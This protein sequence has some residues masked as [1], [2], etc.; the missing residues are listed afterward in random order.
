VVVP[1]PALQRLHERVALLAQRP[2]GQLGQPLRV[3]LAGDQRLQHGA[4]GGAQDLARDRGELD[5]GVLQHLLDPVDR[6]RALLDQAGAEAGQVAQGADRRLRDEAGP[7]QAVLQQLRQPLTV[8]H[9]GL[10]PG[11]RLDV[12]GVGQHDRQVPLQ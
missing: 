8:A 1:Q 3:G 11:D 7:D 12:V 4:A 10:A 5:V 2:A 6:P 9:V